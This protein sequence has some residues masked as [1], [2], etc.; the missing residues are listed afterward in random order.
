MFHHADVVDQLVQMAAVTWRTAG[1]RGA[2]TPT[3]SR[4]SGAKALVQLLHLVLH[5]LD[6]LASRL[7][8]AAED[9]VHQLHPV[10]DDLVELLDVDHLVCELA[11][12]L[13]Q[14]LAEVLQ[15]V[16]DLVD[17][18][19][20]GLVALLDFVLQSGPVIAEVL[21]ELSDAARRAL[22]KCGV[23]LEGRLEGL[24]PLATPAEKSRP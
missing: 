6:L 14:A 5:V 10:G 23:C 15:L 21:V 16:L 13:L 20:A 22:Q 18:L 24:E 11:V 19:R 2:R 7:Q 12:V 9:L 4:R 1:V 17:L 8:V 3:A